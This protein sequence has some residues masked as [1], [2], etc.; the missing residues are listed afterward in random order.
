MRCRNRV[1][2][3]LREPG[4]LSS[5]GPAG[6]AGSTVSPSKRN[7]FPGTVSPSK[8]NTYPHACEQGSV[9]TCLCTQNI[10]MSSASE[11][12]PGAQPLSPAVTIADNLGRPLRHRAGDHR[13]GLLGSWAVLLCHSVSDHG[14]GLRGAGLSVCLG[15][16]PCVTKQ[17][18]PSLYS[19]CGDEMHRS[20]EL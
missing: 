20:R 6:A 3:E 16:F 11:P 15:L 12:R 8:R 4:A 5:S 10:P 18:A 14:E 13:E 9:I 2:C 17:A 1:T 7:T 19:P